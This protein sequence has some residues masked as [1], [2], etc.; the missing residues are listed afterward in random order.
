MNSK[1]LAVKKPRVRDRHLSLE[2]LRIEMNELGIEKLS[3]YV[4][5]K[6]DHIDWPANPMIRYGLSSW[7]AVR[8]VD[9]PKDKLTLDEFKKFIRGQLRSKKNITMTYY[10][11]NIY[12]HAKNKAALPSMPV[13]YYG[14]SWEK[15]IGRP[16]ASTRGTSVKPKRT[17]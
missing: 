1:I 12:P 10:Y 7:Y 3:D 2:A 13:D 16:A 14:V 15:L 17:R 8:G 5:D 11:D 6:P 4:I 9:P